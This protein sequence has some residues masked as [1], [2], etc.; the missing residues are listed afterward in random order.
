MKK[1]MISL[2][3]LFLVIIIG[4]VLFTSAF[5]V[6]TLI[7]KYAIWILLIWLAYKLVKHIWN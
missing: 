3:L 1:T 6:M 4:F 5:V 2:I 7:L